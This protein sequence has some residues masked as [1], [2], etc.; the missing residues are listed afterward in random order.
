MRRTFARTFISLV[1]CT[2]IFSQTSPSPGIMGFG[3]A[4]AETERQAEAKFDSFLKSDNL[5][6]WLKR[7]SARPHHLGSAYDKENAEF[8]AAQFKS[9][10]YDTQIETFD[11]LF[12]TPK[13]RLV[14]MTVPERFA[15][16][17]QEPPLPEDATSGQQN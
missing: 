4:S 14:E 17:L 7:L 1:L 5:R 12:P 11:V 3:S 13:T 8:I 2:S 9:W 15:M 10:G 16:K 6:D